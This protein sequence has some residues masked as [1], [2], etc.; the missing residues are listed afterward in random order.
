[1][2]CS[3]IHEKIKGFLFYHTLFGKAGQALHFPL[4]IPA[5]YLL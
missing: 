4:V 5:P 3:Y 2:L 1:M